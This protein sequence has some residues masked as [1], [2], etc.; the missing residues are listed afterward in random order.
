[1]SRLREFADRLAGVSEGRSWTSTSLAGMGLG[2]GRTTPGGNAVYGVG[3]SNPMAHSAVYACRNLLVRDIS[4]LP[5]DVMRGRAEVPPPTVVSDPSPDPAVPVEAW[6]AQVVDSAVMR[7]NVFGLVTEVEPSGFP[8]K[9]LIVSPDEVSAWRRRDGSIEWRVFNSKV[10]LWQEGGELWHVPLFPSAG[11]FLGPSPLELAR[12]QIELGRTAHGF[13]LSFFRSPQPTGV[14]SIDTPDLT[15]LQASTIKRRF[16]ES[17]QT[18]EP[19]V[20]SR[21]SD[22]RPLSI[23]PEESQF[24]DTIAAN[25]GQIAR[26]FGV[27]ASKIGASTRSGAGDLQ[28]ANI[29]QDQIAYYTDAL[30]PLLVVLERA[31]SR[32]IPRGQ[33]VQFNPEAVLRVDTRTR[34]DAHASALGAGWMV[35][36]EVRELEDL[37]PLPG[38]D[39]PP[40][41]VTIGEGDAG[42]S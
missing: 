21:V 18:R 27:P 15:E 35:V 28:Y 12:Q 13:G 40:V 19:V 30:R 39:R 11:Q 7:G 2:D 42:V 38:G 17:V 8:R 36:N 6:V 41:R 10:S 5:V 32:L 37:P 20:L 22:Y 3:S 14:L 26:Y 25:D 29:E 16:V 33:R 9:V 34:Y 31:W 4:T 1:M 23:T 24:L